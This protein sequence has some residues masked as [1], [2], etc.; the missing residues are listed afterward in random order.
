MYEVVV[1]I[2]ISEE[3]ANFWGC[4]RFLP[5]FSQTWLKSFCATIVSHKGRPFGWPPK[6]G[7]HVILQTLGAIFARIF[8]EFSQIFKGFVKIFTDFA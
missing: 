8:R 5:E 6:K 2:P 7:L 4:E 1:D 3:Q